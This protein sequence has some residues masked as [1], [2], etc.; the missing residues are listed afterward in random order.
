MENINDNNFNCAEN[1]DCNFDPKSIPETKRNKCPVCGNDGV[2]VSTV[3]VE[4][5]V[6]PVLRSEVTGKDYFICMDENCKVV[7][8]DLI[9][10]VKF[11][12]DQVNVPI[13]FK[14]DADPKYA[15]YCSKVTEE[16]VIDAVAMQGAKTV[17]EVNALTG[18]MKNSNCKANNPLGVCCHPII[19]AAID[20]ALLLK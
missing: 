8:F 11:M 1:C 4:H 19:Q 2:A 3:T 20:K 6:R 14:K 15:C 10:G 12:N 16:Q 5:L 13:W 7:Y 18:A 17:K 9:T